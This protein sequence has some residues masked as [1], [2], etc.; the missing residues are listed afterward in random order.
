ML[1]PLQFL[2]TYTNT[3]L[4]KRWTEKEI[5]EL[6]RLKPSMTNS[7]LADIFGTTPGAVAQKCSKLGI[8][9]GEQPNTIHLDQRQGLWLR[10][11]FPHIANIICAL[12]LDISLRSVVRIARRLGLQKTAQ[13]MKECQAHTARK[14]NESHLRNGTYPPKG[15]YSPNLKKGE[16]YRFKPRKRVVS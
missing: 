4:M 2:T 12:Y 13:F 7:E 6:R 9:R 3:E 14:A 10:L 5:A 8:L 15:Y 11:N 1:A 16:A